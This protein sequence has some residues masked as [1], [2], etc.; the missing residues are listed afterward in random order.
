MQ[1]KP[2]RTC[3]PGLRMEIYPHYKINQSQERAPVRQAI[4][5][6]QANI[7]I[8]PTISFT[9]NISIAYRHKSKR[10]KKSLVYL[11]EGNHNYYD[12][13]KIVQNTCQRGTKFIDDYQLI[14]IN[15]RHFSESCK[16][17]SRLRTLSHHISANNINQQW[18]QNKL[19]QKP[20]SRVEIKSN[21]LLKTS[22]NRT[23]DTS[24]SIFYP[25][26]RWIN[27]KAWSQLKL[28]QIQEIK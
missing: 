21:Q 4:L 14:H 17:S 19:A 5:L 13:R 15:D 25:L 11:R 12:Y 24:I 6:R 26:G 23:A 16:I 20:F 10:R 28:W 7:L 22:H 27:T 18:T 9:V 1:R 3:P 8:F 2:Q